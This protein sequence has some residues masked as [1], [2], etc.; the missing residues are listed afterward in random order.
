MLIQIGGIGDIINDEN[1]LTILNALPS[2]FESFVHGIT[3]HDE[4]SSFEKL[5]QED[6]QRTF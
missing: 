2:N 6:H 3:S 4:L 1:V 5:L